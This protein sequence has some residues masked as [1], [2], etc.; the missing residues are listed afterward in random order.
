MPFTA[1][2]WRR[3]D[4]IRIWDYFT[5]SGEILNW[6]WRQLLWN[7]IDQQKMLLSCSSITFSPS[8]CCKHQAHRWQSIGISCKRCLQAI[9]NT[10]L[11]IPPSTLV[12]L[13]CLKAGTGLQEGKQVHGTKP[14]ELYFQNTEWE[15]ACCI[16]RSRSKQD[17][18]SFFYLWR[19]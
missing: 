5:C 17:I 19:G 12:E 6:P 11:L 3:E 8:Q 1:T 7:K 15:K 4:K 18:I 16:L 10:A 13:C 14:R 2:G 9:G